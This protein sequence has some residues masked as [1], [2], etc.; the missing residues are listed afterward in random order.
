MRPGTRLSRILIQGAQH[1]LPKDQ[2]A[3]VAAWLGLILTQDS[4]L[5]DGR[6]FL[7]LPAEHLARAQDLTIP[8]SF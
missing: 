3:F 6:S 5:S 1:D 7:G 8:L 2:P 4:R